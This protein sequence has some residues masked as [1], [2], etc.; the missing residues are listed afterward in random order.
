M[1]RFRFGLYFFPTG[2]RPSSFLIIYIKIAAMVGVE[3]MINDEKERRQMS[4]K[5]K[6]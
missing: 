2:L 5:V 3:T 6:K 4:T 1:D